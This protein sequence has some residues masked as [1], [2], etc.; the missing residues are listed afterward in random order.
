MNRPSDYYAALSDGYAEK[1]RQL[2]PRYDEM[3]DCI[4]ELLALCSPCRLLD[5]GAGVGNLAAILSER[6]P[7]CRI[8]ALESSAE[9]VAAARS[10]LGDVGDRIAILQRDVLD[11]TPETRFDAIYSNLVLHNLT[12][13]DK[14]RLLG[15]L[16]DWLD[17]DGAFIWGDLIRHP[18]HRVQDHFVEYRRAFAQA[19]GCPADLVRENFRKETC[20]DHPLTVEGTLELARA[21]G[22]ER[23]SVVWAHDTFAIFQLR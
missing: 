11:F 14:A 5:I 16:R 22:F 2:V 9:M 13:G 15:R 20:D 1:I 8:T 6:L 19:A 3:L 18:D 4:V 10:A 21:S 12:A 17:P 7:N 23:R